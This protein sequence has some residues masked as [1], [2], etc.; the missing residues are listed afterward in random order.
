MVIVK[1]GNETD[2]IQEAKKLGFES[3]GL[4]YTAGEVKTLDKAHLKALVDHAGIFLEFGV[5]QESTRTI[6]KP[7]F[8]TI[9]IALGT[10]ISN[11]SGTITHLANNEFEEEKDFHHQRRGGLNHVVLAKLAEKKGSVLLG[12]RALLKLD[13]QKQAQILG[14]AAQNI[15][16]CKRKKVDYSVVSLAKKPQDMRTA[17]DLEAFSRTLN[18]L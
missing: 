17:K 14:R 10:K 6:Y 13:A 1:K 16:S 8:C 18:S 15:A 9:H 4:I 7:D 5:I 2:F 11:I 3:L 12:I